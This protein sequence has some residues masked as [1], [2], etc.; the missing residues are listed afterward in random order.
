MRFAQPEFLW[1]IPAVVLLVVATWL[2]GIRRR[3]SLMSKFLGDA[4]RAWAANGAVSWRRSVDLLLVGVA[5]VMLVLSLSRPLLFRQDEQAELRGVP[6]IIAL[7]LSRS[8]L[9]TDV[10]PN[11][12]SLATNSLS[13]FLELANA[14][15]VGLITFS[16]VAYLNAPLSFDT[17]AIQTMLRYSSP[18]SFDMDGETAGSDLG[19]A[20]ERAGRYFTSNNISPRV[21]ILVTD[22]EDSGDQLLNIARRWTRQG[23]KVCAIGVGTRAG[24]KVPRINWG[25]TAQN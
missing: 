10:R 5:G 23:L 7:D 1:A 25:G 20:I 4:K 21:V 12:W 14:D 16:G 11:R 9:A 18:Y 8:M 6:Y 2:L 19:A 3:R 15:R 17:R 22:G 13:R 24:S